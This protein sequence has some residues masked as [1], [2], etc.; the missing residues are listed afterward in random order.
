MRA[1]VI[2]IARL[3]HG[4]RMTGESSVRAMAAY[5]RPQASRRAAGIAAQEDVTVL[6]GGTDVYP[7]S[8]ARRRLGRHAP[9]RRP[10]HQRHQRACSGIAEEQGRLR[11]GA[12]AT[13][14]ELRRAPLPA[15]FAGY[16]AAA[17]EVGGAQMQ[18]RGTLVGNICTAS[19][20]GDGIPCLLT[21]DAEVELA[22]LRGWRVVPVVSFIGGYRQ[23]MCAGR[24]DR[25]R[26]PG[27]RSPR[28][29]RAAR[30]VKLGARRYLVISIVMAAAVLDAD[31][32][33]ASWQRARR[34]RRLLGRGA[35]AARSW[36]GRW[37]D[38]PLARRPTSSAAAHLA[39][40][41]PIDDIRACGAFRRHAA[42]QAWCAI[43]SLASR[44]SRSGGPPDARSSR[45]SPT[46][47]R[48]GRVQ[49]E[50]QPRQR[51]GRARSRRLP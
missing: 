21:L 47:R 16:Q 42:L 1:R 51:R 10:R 33:G 13:W 20:A 7:A 46:L 17:R 23:T 11:F 9:R 43:S 12:L 31:R 25:H 36:S 34:R 24:R 40:L 8:A 50:R 45:A 15:A 19:P 2:R 6:A 48:H 41:A 49:P 35:A 3:R 38:E 32:G 37:S 44:A 4:F 18:N 26:H 5:F 30:F 22:C 28:P 29:A 39:A 27:S 14:T